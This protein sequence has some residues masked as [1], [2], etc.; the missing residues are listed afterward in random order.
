[1]QSLQQP[2]LAISPRRCLPTRCQKLTPARPEKHQSAQVG[3]RPGLGSGGRTLRPSQCN[4]RSAP[5]TRQG[6]TL[7]RPRTVRR[8]HAV[9]QRALSS[10]MQPSW[11]MTAATPPRTSA[12][13]ATPWATCHWNGINTRNTS[14]M[15][16]E[17]AH[18][19]H[20][21]QSTTQPP[22]RTCLEPL[23]TRT[24]SWIEYHSCVCVSHMP[25]E[26][27]VS[28]SNLMPL[29]SETHLHTSGG[30]SGPT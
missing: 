30:S 20:N 5:V 12:P 13:P 3:Q 16:G 9:S 21:M 11:R 8:Y 22:R 14:A 15:T 26:T 17:P 28:C 10:E 29:H 1:M 19:V 27:F 6:R 7:A 4:R 18:I 25:D 2:V 24:W 23:S